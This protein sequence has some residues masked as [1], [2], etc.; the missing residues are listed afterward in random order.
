MVASPEVEDIS[1]NVASIKEGDNVLAVQAM[2]RSSGGSDFVIGVE[3]L[4]EV[5]DTSG[6]CNMDFLKRQHQEAEWYNFNKPPS[7]VVF[8]SESQLFENDLNCHLVQ[9]HQE[10]LFDIQLTSHCQLMNLDLNRNYIQGQF[11]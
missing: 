7:E 10:Q 5:Q 3:L 11:L 8:S 6:E 4:A 9:K 1:S 2:N